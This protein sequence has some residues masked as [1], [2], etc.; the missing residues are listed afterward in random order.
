MIPKPSDILSDSSRRETFPTPPFF[1]FFQGLAPRLLP[2]TG[3]CY[4]VS[5]TALLLPTIPLNMQQMVH[6]V[7]ASIGRAAGRKALATDAV[8]RLT[9]R[10]PPAGLSCRTQ[11]PANPIPTCAR[12][13][14]QI[15]EVGKTVDAGSITKAYRKLARK[16]HPDKGGDPEEFKALSEAYEV[17]A[18]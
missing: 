5:F 14:P 1:F 12:S 10:V 6:L 18:E 16:K 15:L 9:R 7:V 17:R 8:C 11:R 4:L 3:A 2:S 13:L